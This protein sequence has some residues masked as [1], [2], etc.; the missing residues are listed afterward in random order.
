VNKNEKKVDNIMTDQ[1]AFEEELKNYMKSR[2]I[3]FEDHCASM[4]TLD[5]HLFYRKKKMTGL[6]IT[7]SSWQSWR[8]PVG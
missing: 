3:P 1:P 4:N 7:L 5:F 6:I 2:N 8:Q